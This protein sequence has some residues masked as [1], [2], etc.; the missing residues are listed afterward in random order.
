[1]RVRVPVLE[2]YTVIESYKVVVMCCARARW[3]RVVGARGSRARETG[4]R[5]R[6]AR[7]WGGRSC[8]RACVRA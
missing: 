4:V 3:V 1:M 7:V 6:D 5:E 2:S 8:V